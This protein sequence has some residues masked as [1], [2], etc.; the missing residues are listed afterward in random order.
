MPLEAPLAVTLNAEALRPLIVEVVR[1]VL[2]QVRDAEARLPDKIAFTEP[3]AARLLSLNVW[4]LRDE[5]LRGRIVA[6]GV[7]GRRVRYRRED[8]VQYLTERKT[9]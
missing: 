9:A 6:S 2:A 8:L 4:Q 7:V 1:E 5:R 3:E